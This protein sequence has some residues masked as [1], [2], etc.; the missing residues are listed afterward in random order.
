MTKGEKCM[1]LKLT[2]KEKGQPTIVKGKYI[3]DVGWL[4]ACT[5][6]KIYDLIQGSSEDSWIVLINDLGGKTY[7]HKDKFIEIEKLYTKQ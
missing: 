5:Y 2:D 1:E 4:D 7:L 3:G 6:G